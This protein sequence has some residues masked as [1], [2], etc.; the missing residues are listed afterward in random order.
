MIPI[1]L[2]CIIA[3]YLVVERGVLFWKIRI[4]A[5]TF[6]ET[7]FTLLHNGKCDLTLENCAKVRHPIAKVLMA[8]IEHWKEPA[9]DIERILSRTGSEQI[10]LLEKN[11]SILLVIIGVEPML[12]FLGT[13]IG[14]IQSFM[15]WEAAGASTTVEQLSG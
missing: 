9:S 11:M 13:V 3:L 12:G 7:I 5:R 4:N 2:G 14:L 1:I 15:A 6:T 8:G 10:A